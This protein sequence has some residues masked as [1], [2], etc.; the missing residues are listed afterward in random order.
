MAK[1]DDQKKKEDR[2]DEDEQVEKNV[3]PSPTKKPPRTDLTNR[4]LQ[5]KDPDLNQKDPDMSMNFKDIGGSE[6]TVSDR[7][8][9]RWLNSFT[10]TPKEDVQKDAEEEEDTQ[11]VEYDVLEDEEESVEDPVEVVELDE[12]EIYDAAVQVYRHSDEDLAARL[13]DEA[14]K[15]IAEKAFSLR[16]EPLPPDW[17]PEDAFVDAQIR[18]Q[19]RRKFR[20]H[21]SFWDAATFVRNITYFKEKLLNESLTTGREDLED[22][23]TLL[24]E[25]AEEAFLDLQHTEA[26]PLISL[27]VALAPLDDPEGPFDNNEV[28]TE[29]IS[30]WKKQLRRT[31][32]ESIAK[33]I[34]EVESRITNVPQDTNLYHW[35]ARLKTIL[36]GASAMRPNLDPKLIAASIRS[37]IQKSAQYRGLDGYLERDEYYMPDAPKWKRPDPRELTAQDYAWILIEAV[38]WFNDD[39]LKYDLRESNP[40]MA[41]RIALDYAIYVTNEGMY[42]SRIDAPTYER[43][44]GIM[45]NVVL[46]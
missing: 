19:D 14:G 10:F 36:N 30:N 5:T 23:Y 11:E 43:L 27:E 38:G 16:L 15:S 6:M 22:Y 41:C 45:R 32:P 46:K 33:L 37:G 9:W 2:K 44:L 31:A 4:R 13:Q 25:M 24:I 12:K 8:A 1:S 7:V 28:L 18:L 34:D 29:A 39:F 17:V 3:K 21:M 20:K 40:G 42:Q 35:L 26:K